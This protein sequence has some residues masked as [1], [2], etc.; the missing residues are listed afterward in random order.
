MKDNFFIG[1][2]RLIH[3]QCRDLRVDSSQQTP[4]LASF[5]LL[6]TINDEIDHGGTLG[7]PAPALS[8]GDDT[9]AETQITKKGD[10]EVLR[11]DYSK[12]KST[13]KR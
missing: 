5:E 8:R 1:K 11:V 7:P 9:G 10:R 13:A 4:E 2:R 6:L 3:I 12:K